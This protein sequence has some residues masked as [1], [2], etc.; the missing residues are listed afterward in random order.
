MHQ[1]AHACLSI[2]TLVRIF[3]NNL[4]TGIF[5]DCVKSE[6][7]SFVQGYVLILQAKNRILSDEATI[8]K[9]LAPEILR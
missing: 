6:Q 2:G 7:R 9:G 8:F 3:Q 5:L 4:C 1:F